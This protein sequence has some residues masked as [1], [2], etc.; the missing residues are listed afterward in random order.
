[1]IY[2]IWDPVILIT[3]GLAI[4]PTAVIMIS[5]RFIFR[6]GKKVNQ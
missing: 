3:L 2:P 6:K 5:A 4:A 1:M